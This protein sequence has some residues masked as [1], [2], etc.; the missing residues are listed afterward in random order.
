MKHTCHTFFL[1][2]LAL[3]F[4][5]QIC[6]AQSEEEVPTLDFRTLGLTRG[7]SSDLFYAT[8]DGF[9]KLPLSY[10]RPSSGKTARLAEDGSLPL[11]REVTDPEEG[12]TYI[13][14]TRVRIP[15]GSKQILIL[16]AGTDDGLKLNAVKDNISSSNQDWLLINVSPTPMAIQLGDEDQ[17]IRVAPGAS[18]IHQ[19][20]LESGK[21]AAIQ[22]AA[23]K[24]NNWERVYSRFW[25]IYD[26]QRCMVIFLE[27]NGEIKVY[28]FFEA[29][30]APDDT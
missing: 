21:G 7:I 24:E 6:L 20:D 29:V 3:I 25:P 27:L 30:H 12:I 2:L 13:P 22:V 15:E 23:F 28:N 11:F 26:G 17:P 14:H 8:R 9:E 1:G 19:V 10:F 18:V 4:T 16:G 5:L